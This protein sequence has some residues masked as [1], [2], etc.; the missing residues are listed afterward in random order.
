MIATRDGV[1]DVRLNRCRTVIGS[2]NQIE[3][4]K[5]NF[6]NRALEFEDAG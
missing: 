4:V 3:A 1:A 2:P 6:E 5:A